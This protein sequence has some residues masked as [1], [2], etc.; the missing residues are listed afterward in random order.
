MGKVCRGARGQETTIVLKEIRPVCQNQGLEKIDL[1]KMLLCC[2]GGQILS[3]QRSSVLKKKCG[4]MKTLGTK[5][6]LKK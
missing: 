1:I 4:K 5:S 2:F 3:K 6:S